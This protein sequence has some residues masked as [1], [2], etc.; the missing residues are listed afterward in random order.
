MLAAVPRADVVVMNP[1]HYAVALA[2][3]ERSMAAP[4]VIAK[5]V[6]R[7]A[8]RIRDTAA[9]AGVPVLEAPP[10]ARAL[11]AHAR[12]DGEVPASLFA[13]VAQVLA[14]VYG[15]KAALPGR[16]APP[17]VPEVPAGLDPGP[18]AVAED[19]G[20]DATLAPRRAGGDA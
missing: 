18:G 20:F 10:L 3:D 11:H 6:D 2:Y 7:L 14:W 4:R 8:L 13:A 17:P 12:L 16:E 1:S 19:E 15:L 9:A 5:G